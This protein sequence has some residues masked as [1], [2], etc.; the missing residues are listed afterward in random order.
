M[1]YEYVKHKNTFPGKFKRR[2]MENK[3]EKG[4]A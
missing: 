4:K 2:I 3:R 1:D